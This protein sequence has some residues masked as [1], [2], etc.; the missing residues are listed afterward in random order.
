MSGYQSE[1][2]REIWGDTPEELVEVGPDRDGFGCVE[3]RLRLDGK[4]VERMSFA[5]EQA[6]LVAE[7]IKACATEL[8]QVKP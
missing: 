8:R 5:P 7:A 1:T 3:V 4:I 6:D 2:L